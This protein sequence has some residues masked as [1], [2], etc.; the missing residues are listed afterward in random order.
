MLPITLES[1]R[2][3]LDAPTRADAAAIT[4]PPFVFQMPAEELISFLP[5]GQPTKAT[6]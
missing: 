3:R 1:A 4:A 2:V 6:L 5:S